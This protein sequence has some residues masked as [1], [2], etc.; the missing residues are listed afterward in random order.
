MKTPLP[1]L[2]FARTLWLIALGS[3]GTAL[4]TTSVLLRV[5][6]DNENPIPDCTIYWQ[7]P[8]S[9]GWQL[10]R[11][12]YRVGPSGV[13][14]DG[15]SLGKV[16][17][18]VPQAAEANP[19]MGEALMNYS[20]SFSQS[21][22]GPFSIKVTVD[23]YIPVEQSVGQV[24]PY[25]DRYFFQTVH[26]RR[27]RHEDRRQEPPPQSAAEQEGSYSITIYFMRGNNRPAPNVQF[28][29][30]MQNSGHSFKGSS[31]GNGEASLTLPEYGPCKVVYYKPNG[32]KAE[33][34]D[35][36]PMNAHKDITI[37][38]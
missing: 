3:V 13:N 14:G 37:F 28:T 22:P 34:G 8:S 7:S 29:V 19:S 10:P 32:Q 9:A 20:V 17:E 18:T 26:L 33:V 12:T 36:V 2:A 1:F 30:V 16:R 6:D 4:A 5:T 11:V 27:E 21:K 35:V 38:W 24:D 25:H 15:S 31:N 23:G